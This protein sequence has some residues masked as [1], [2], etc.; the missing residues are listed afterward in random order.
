MPSTFTAC[1]P[2]V[3]FAKSFSVVM[4]SFQ[5]KVDAKEAAKKKPK[6]KRGKENRCQNEVLQGEG[7]VNGKTKKKILTWGSGV[8]KMKAHTAGA[9]RRATGHKSNGL[10]ILS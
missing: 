5:A 10:S 7:L 3:D 1:V 9:A 8:L 6:S 4:D 2:T